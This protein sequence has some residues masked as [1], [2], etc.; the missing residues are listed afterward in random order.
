MEI[1]ADALRLDCPRARCAA[2]GFGGGIGGS[3]GPCGAFSA[4]LI[5]IG[6]FFG[7]RLQP[8]GCIA[9]AVETVVQ[10]YHDDWMEAFGS[11][12]C[13]R[14]SGFPELRSDEAR[15]AFFSSGGPETCTNRYIRSATE[16]TM[17]LLGP[18]KDE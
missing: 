3:G 7:E 16:Q 5:A 14:L 15:D 1:L 4:G 13:S 9:E 8:R 17:R 6:M 11:I 10:T 2:A 18:F 12:M